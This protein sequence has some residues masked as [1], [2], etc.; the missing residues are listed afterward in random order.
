VEFN[1]WATLYNGFF[2]AGYIALLAFVPGEIALPVFGLIS[3]LSGLFSLILTFL[4]ARKFVGSNWAL[5]AMFILSVNPLFAQYFVSPGPDMVATALGMSAIYLAISAFDSKTS[6]RSTILLYSAAGIVTGAGALIRLHVLA[7]VLVLVLSTLFVEKGRRVVSA[8]AYLGSVLAVYSIQVVVNISSGLGPL[9]SNTAYTVYE[10]A[11]PA[12]WYMTEKVDPIALGTSSVTAI[13]QLIAKY[14]VQIMASYLN[15]FQFFQVGLVLGLI[16]LVLIRTQNQAKAMGV[17]VFSF[18][19]IAFTSSL[20]YSERGFTSVLPL[21]A[22]FIAVTACQLVRRFSEVSVRK[23][24]AFAAVSVVLVVVAIPQTIETLSRSVSFYGV[25]KDKLLVENQISSL[26]GGAPLGTLLTTDMDLFLRERDELLPSRFGGWMTVSLNGRQIPPRLDIS[27]LQGLA[28][29]AES[30]GHDFLLWPGGDNYV[31]GELN[32][33]F[34]SGL[35]VEGF[36]FLG[37]SGNFSVFKI[38]TTGI[39]C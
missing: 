13:L 30:S 37:R 19:A 33:S 17:L 34:N 7:L 1:D 24:A 8:I 9:A 16:A 18:A 27:T 15:G 21:I 25:Q 29:T 6:H 26:T 4:L 10:D 3:L 14:P 20:A 39:D 38:S 23:V 5:V 2:P 35:S 28:C 31:F 32:E 12:D 11:L 22:I 36:E